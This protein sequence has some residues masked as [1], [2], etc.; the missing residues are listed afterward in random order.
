MSDLTDEDIEFIR[1]LVE[2]IL[3]NVSERTSEH[4]GAPSVADLER[5]GASASEDEIK[6]LARGASKTM[7]L[8]SFSILVAAK[9]AMT[10]G[11]KMSLLQDGRIEEAVKGIKEMIDLAEEKSNQYTK[12]IVEDL[13]HEREHR[14]TKV[15]GGSRI[16][17]T[18]KPL[19]GLTEDDF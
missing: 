2:D 1:D 17:R 10:M 6:K 5:L 9:V 15:T 7:F 4:V 18:D 3:G 16:I 13:L 11:Y 12:T 19:A 14:D 8:L